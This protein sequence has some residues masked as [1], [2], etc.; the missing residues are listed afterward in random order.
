MDVRVIGGDGDA[1]LTENI[2]VVQ[3]DEGRVV[4]THGG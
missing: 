1:W 4:G 3:W 2:G